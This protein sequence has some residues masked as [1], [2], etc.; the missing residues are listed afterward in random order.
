VI[1]PRSY[2][3]VYRQVADLLRA[4]IVSGDVGPGGLLGTE[5]RIAAEHGVGRDTARAALAELRAEGLITM[6]LQGAMIADL[7][8]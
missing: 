7:E 3:P 2:V 8:L 5:G 1:D 4:R 6:T